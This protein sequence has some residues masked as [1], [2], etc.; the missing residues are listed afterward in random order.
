MCGQQRVTGWLGLWVVIMVS[1]ESSIDADELE[2]PGLN[3]ERGRNDRSGAYLATC[4]WATRSGDQRLPL[5]FV[6]GISRHTTALRVIDL[7]AHRSRL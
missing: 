3:E 5:S 7:L 4:T 6:C 2:R 1:R